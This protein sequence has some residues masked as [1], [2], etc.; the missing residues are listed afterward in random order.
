MTG[1][2]KHAKALESIIDIRDESDR[3]GIRSVIE[4]K[5]I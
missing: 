2:K 1:D 3:T 4:I 5:R